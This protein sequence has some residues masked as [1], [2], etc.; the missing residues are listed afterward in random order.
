MQRYCAFA[1]ILAL[2][3]CIPIAPVLVYLPADLPSAMHGGCPSSYMA[4][5]LDQD[6][7]ALDLLVYPEEGQFSGRLSLDIPRGRNAAIL[8]DYGMTIYRP[9]PLGPLT[10]LLECSAYPRLDPRDP[11]R[12]DCRFVAHL[13]EGSELVVN[14][15]PVEIN[16]S[17]YDLSPMRFSLQKRPAVCW[18]SA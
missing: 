16:G 9:A 11:P 4:R 2:G 14:F 3:A 12:R 6:G 18:I 5:L 13:S 10:A 15:P 7:V 17:R 1:M 8:K